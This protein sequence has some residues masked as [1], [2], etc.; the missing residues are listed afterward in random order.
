M[1]RRFAIFALAWSVAFLVGAEDWPQFRGPHANGVSLTA[2]PPVS[3]SEGEN[4]RWKAHIEGAGSSTPIV[5][6]DRVFVIASVNTGK[7]DPALPKP[8]DQPKRVFGITHPNTLYEFYA[9]CLSRDN[10]GEIWKTKVNDLIPHE[11]HHGDV[12]VQ[13]YFSCEKQVT[14]A[15]VSLLSWASSITRLEAQWITL[16]GSSATLL[17][18]ENVIVTF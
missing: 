16:N 5:W 4:I 18:Q 2:K 15:Q 12:S 8:E 10:G 1:K 3:W 7:V 6:Q 17:N 13:Y 11:G 9:I 14:Q